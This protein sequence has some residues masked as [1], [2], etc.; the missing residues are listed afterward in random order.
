M[1]YEMFIEGLHCT[2]GRLLASKV[3]FSIKHLICFKEFIANNNIIATPK[4]KTK[5]VKIELKE[6]Y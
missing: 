2:T 3:S 4:I 6:W 1:Y 5:D